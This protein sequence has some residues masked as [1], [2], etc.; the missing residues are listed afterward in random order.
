MENNLVERI[1]K[2]F[3]EALYTHAKEAAKADEAVEAVEYF[4]TNIFAKEEA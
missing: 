3:G 2:G 1:L 4:E